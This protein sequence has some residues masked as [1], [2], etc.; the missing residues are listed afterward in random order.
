MKSCVCLFYYPTSVQDSSTTPL[1]CHSV[2]STS[3]SIASAIGSDG[4]ADSDIFPLQCKT[5]LFVFILLIFTRI[6]FCKRLNFVQT[7][8]VKCNADG[9]SVF[10]VYMNG[11][12]CKKSY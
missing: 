10:V 9:E 11:V 7:H 8:S 12:E 3:T 6:T 2:L 4:R 5:L 1:K